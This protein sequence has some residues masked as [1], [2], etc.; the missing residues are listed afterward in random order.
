MTSDALRAALADRYRTIPL[1]PR[2]GTLARS[3]Y[4]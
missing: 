1:V 4:Q 2:A 3:Q